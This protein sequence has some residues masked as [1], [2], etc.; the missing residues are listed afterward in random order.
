MNISRKQAILALLI[1][2]AVVSGT[3]LVTR[4]YFTD[5]ETGTGSQF[6]VGTLDLDV[7]GANG[8]EIA[9]FVIEN[10]GEEGNIAGSQTWTVNNTGSLPGRLYFKLDNLVNYENDCNEPEALVDVTCDDPGAG[11]GDLGGVITARVYLDNVEKMSSTLATANQ[12][13]IGD[14]WTA[15]PDVVV[16]AGGSVEVKMDW[17]TGQADYGNEIQSDSLAFDMVFDLVQI[18]EPTPAP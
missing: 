4:A 2:C 6:A 1:I 15:L 16:P 3:A 13:V 17:A 12:S 7:G 5:R 18:I 10:M 11:Q 9:P 14:A 8:T